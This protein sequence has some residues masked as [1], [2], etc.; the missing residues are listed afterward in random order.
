M[1]K[2]L[3]CCSS[4]VFQT[5]L[6][7]SKG[8]SAWE[9]QSSYEYWLLVQ[10]FLSSFTADLIST[11]YQAELAVKFISSWSDFLQFLQTQLFEY[12]IKGASLH[13]LPC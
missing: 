2:H 11:Y 10:N 1:I 6:A 7:A 3:L 8:G 12:Q 4:F 5:S 13:C 9:L